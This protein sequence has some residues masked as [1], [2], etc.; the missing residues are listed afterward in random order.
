MSTYDREVYWGRVAKEI[1][2]RGENFVAGDDNPFYQ[3]KRQKCLA[4]FLDRIEIDS[5]VVMEL[6][7]GPG[8]NLIHLAQR[9]RP[10]R[11]HGVDIAHPM[12]ELAARNL[13]EVPHVDLRKTDGRSIP[14]AN[15]SADISFTVTVLQHNTDANDFARMVS[16]LCR[17]SAAEVVVMEDIGS[18]ARVRSAG[19]FL[20]RPISAYE[21]EFSRNGFTLVRVRFLRT[22]ASRMWYR[23]VYG[24]YKVL[25]ARSRQEGQPL[26]WLL[27]RILELTLPA[28]RALDRFLP[29]HMDLAQLV[30][31]RTGG[32]TAAAE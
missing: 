16:E 31:R 25:F 27:Q 18:G 6:G 30:F 23:L 29:D 7:C 9:G 21:A 19:S 32:P 24:P 28:T 17:V 2:Q 11:L 15:R 5:R 10:S 3:Y 8:G 12:L 20:A 14:F 26:P 1:D 4:E 13:R 22:R